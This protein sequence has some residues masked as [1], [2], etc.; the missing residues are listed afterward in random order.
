MADKQQL[1]RLG[2]LLIEEGAITQ[3]ELA[4]ALDEGGP[5]ASPLREAL[6]VGTHVRR[7]DLAAA[8][9]NNFAIPKMESIKELKLD[10][11]LAKLVPV[12]SARKH[13]MV[14]L[15]RL[16]HILCVGK[17]NYYNRAAVI[18]LR[19]AT[20]LK[21]KV[22]LCPE[23]QVAAAIE[24]LYGSVKA[25]PEQAPMVTPLV[26]QPAQPAASIPVPAPMVTPVAPQKPAVADSPLS[27][28]AAASAPVR[29]PEEG[30]WVL[31]DPLVAQGPTPPPPETETAPAPAAAVT[32]PTAAVPAAAPVSV[33]PAA[34]KPAGAPV[35]PGPV[36]IEK[37]PVAA[38][39]QPQQS[40][41]APG[42]ELPTV[43]GSRVRAVPISAAAF[44]EA[45]RLAERRPDAI[46]GL[47]AQSDR[48]VPA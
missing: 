33:S 24:R 32:T 23:E 38:P 9:A 8:L 3:E 36:R 13:E 39:T 29:A 40:V 28:P 5:A 37:P 31:V 48:P 22:V 35:A 42:L 41:P 30:D 15:A 26:A 7:E 16:G 17:A 34:P 43:V 11:E 27:V 1:V 12:E 44:E 19:K 4:R 46:L 10:P 45:R 6:H 2:E 18:E 47:I 21:I 14:P 25:A 20:G